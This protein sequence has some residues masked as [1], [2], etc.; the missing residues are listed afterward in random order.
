MSSG[1]V[2]VSVADEHGQ[3]VDAVRERGR[4]VAAARAGRGSGRASTCTARGR[5]AVRSGTSPWRRRPRSARSTAASCG[6]RPRFATGRRRRRAGSS[7]ST[8]RATAR[9]A[10]PGTSRVPRRA[11]CR[12]HRRRARPGRTGRAASAR[13]PVWFA[14]HDVADHGLREV[15]VRGEVTGLQRVDHRRP[16]DLRDVHVTERRL[17]VPEHRLACD[18]L[19][20][21]ADD[22]DDVEV[23]KDRRRG[24]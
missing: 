19:L 9:P 22:G 20:P 11:V 15:L 8:A 6:S 12:T 16:V 3:H 13:S 24:R 18:H 21:L 23:L 1:L 14:D 2:P 5:S 10:A 4:V 17:H 7:P